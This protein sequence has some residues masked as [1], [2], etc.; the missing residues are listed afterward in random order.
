LVKQIIRDRSREII[1][2]IDVIR[3]FQEIGCG[4]NEEEFGEM[5]VGKIWLHVSGKLWN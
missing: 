2:A 5:S 1:V 3:T 4:G